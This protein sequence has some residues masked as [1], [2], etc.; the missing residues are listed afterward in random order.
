[1]ARVRQRTASPVLGFYAWP[2]GEVK[3]SSDWYSQS[4]RIEDNPP[5]M[6]NDLYIDKCYSS[7]ATVS[8]VMTELGPN[9]VSNWC[10]LGFRSPSDNN[11]IPSCPGSPTNGEAAAELLAKTNP[12]RPDVSIPN[13]IYE[14]REFPKLFKFEGDNLLS[15]FGGSYLNGQ[16]GWTPLISDMLKLVDFSDTVSNRVKELG[17]LHN[18]GLRRKRQLFRGSGKE[19]GSVSL[20]SHQLGLGAD[21]SSS[22]TERVWGYVEWHPDKGDTPPHTA[23]E[24]R[25]L[26]R[27]AVLG[28]TVDLSVAWEAMPWSWLIDWSANIGDY[29]LAKRNIVNASPG[30]VYIM[31]ERK[32]VTTYVPHGNRLYYG[33]GHPTGLGFPTVT[34]SRI[35]RS[36]TRSVPSINAQLPFLSG[37]QMSILGA[38]GVTRRAGRSK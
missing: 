8:G 20:H 7:P 26:A 4:E 25:A 34:R 5:G 6:W 12:S 17:F 33:G 36:R 1:M 24:M 3:D 27:R 31:R 2:N 29:L 16:F 18:G 30:P 23:D 14:L 10:P 9:V 21:Y 11:P 37:R 38:I 15:R 22:S 19:T 28:L 13:F 32:G 35:Q